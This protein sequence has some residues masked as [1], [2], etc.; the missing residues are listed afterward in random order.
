MELPN[1]LNDEYS[2]DYDKDTVTVGMMVYCATEGEIYNVVN[3]S[4]FSFELQNE[5]WDSWIVSKDD[6]QETLYQDFFPVSLT[7]YYPD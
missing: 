4:R 3:E 6:I 7:G 2:I 5:N 1:S